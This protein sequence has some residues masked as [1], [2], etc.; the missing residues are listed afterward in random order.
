MSNPFTCP[1]TPP[2]VRSKQHTLTTPAK[3]PDH[4]LLTPCTSTKKAIQFKTPSS[5]AKKPIVSSTSS[6]LPLT[7]E[8]TPQQSPNRS[9][10]RRKVFPD[11]IFKHA[12]DSSTTLGDKLSFG[13]LLPTP[14]TVGS[15]RKAVHKVR[16]STKQAQMPI[17]NLEE[18][19]DDEIDA[20]P[21]KEPLTPSKQLINDD[22]VEHWHGK[23]F[24]NQYSSDEE[25]DSEVKP[26]SNP[27]VDASSPKGQ[28]AKRGANP[29]QDTFAS[30]KDEIDYRTH[31]ELVNKNGAKRL[32][33]LTS[34]QS[35]IKPKKLDF[36]TC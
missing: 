2:R 26:L 12:T 15:G 34:H 18:E 13:L 28:R 5:I 4:K 11:E 36:S 27:F 17:L 6:L 3:Q 25:S 21:I 20:T 30:P 7:P 22:L 19:V 23:S 32:I 29:F 31:M 35:K 8:F 14:S 10:R 1:Q 33:K 16:G 9:Q 24:N